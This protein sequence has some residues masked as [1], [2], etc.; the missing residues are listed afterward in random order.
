MSFRVKFYAD[1]AFF[2]MV[3]RILENKKQY[4]GE[5]KLAFEPEESAT[6][7]LICHSACEA[8]LNLFANEVP[9]TDFIKYERKSIIDKIDFLYSQKDQKADWSKLPLQDIRN[10]DKSRNWLTHFKNSDI[11]LINSTGKWVIDA[12]NEKPKIDDAIE[13]KYERVERY[14]ENIRKSLFE[15]AKLYNDQ[16]CFDYLETEK[17]ASYLIG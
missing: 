17:F 6:A 1:Q 3:K 12:S 13:L 10:L 7:I 15:I 14:Y 5:Q 16:D 4:S 8:F 11:G 2:S 9:I